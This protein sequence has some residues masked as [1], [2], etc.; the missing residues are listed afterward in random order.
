MNPRTRRKRRLRRK[1]RAYQRLFAHAPYV[2]PGC[3]AV[4]GEPCAPGCIDASIEEARYESG[5]GYEPLETPDYSE[6]YI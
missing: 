2:C 1:E 4:G 3:Y 6:A 5:G